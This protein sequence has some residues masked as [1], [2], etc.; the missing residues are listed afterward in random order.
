MEL[1]LYTEDYFDAAHFLIGYNGKCS[2]LHGHTWKISL[3]IRGD[4]KDKDQSGILWDFG[5]LKKVIN[6]FDHK[7]LN[8][9]S[10]ESPSVENLSI[11]IYDNLKT[12]YPNLKFKVRV[13][14]EIHPKIA[15]CELGD[16][17]H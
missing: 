14:E 1:T 17:T 12:E 2:N 16:F 10:S 9:I 3:W 11:F 8:E 7:N 6:L 4:S 5:N 13:Y 15:Y